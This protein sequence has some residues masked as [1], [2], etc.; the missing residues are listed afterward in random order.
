MSKWYYPPPFRLLLVDVVVSGVNSSVLYSFFV[1]GFGLPTDS[2][3]MLRNPSRLAAVTNMVSCVLPYKPIEAEA[4]GKSPLP[5]FYLYFVLPLAIAFWPGNCHSARYWTV[6]VRHHHI[7]INNFS[8]APALFDT[9][10]VTLT[11][12]SH[13]S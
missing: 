11:L 12:H 4:S 2:L 9:L 6:H 13:Y 8:C 1:S 5:V 10:T 3:L 7:L